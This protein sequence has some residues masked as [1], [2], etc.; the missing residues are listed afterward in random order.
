MQNVLSSLALHICI[1]TI[2]IISPLVVFVGNIG[3][4]SFEGRINFGKKGV[5]EGVDIIIGGG[6]I[7]VHLRVLSAYACAF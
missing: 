4:S 6:S 3:R 5:P 7:S 1:V 2:C